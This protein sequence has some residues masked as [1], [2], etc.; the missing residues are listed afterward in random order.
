MSQRKERR[1]KAQRILRAL[2]WG[3]LHLDRRRPFRRALKN[4]K[5]GY[6]F[7][8]KPLRVNRYLS[9]RTMAALEHSYA[10]LNKGLPT[11]S[12][13]FS[14]SEWQCKDIIHY[15]HRMPGCEAIKVNR[16]LLLGLEA[17]RA[18]FYPGGL[19]PV[20]GY[21]CPKYNAT[22]PGAASQSQHMDGNACD[23]PPTVPYGQM[24]SLQKFS[25]I[26]IVKATGKVAH[27]D[28]RDSGTPSNPI[29]WY[30]Y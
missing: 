5:R 29:I 6:A 10:R 7:G 19:T 2:G 28:V 13:H 16:K 9:K 11:A 15:G 1:Q 21:R 18:K 12:P 14:F 8:D 3:G 25:G 4:F 27:V 26:G 23:T 22:L 24:R 30:Y 17:L 20:S